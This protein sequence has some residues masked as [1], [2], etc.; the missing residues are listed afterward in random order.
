[1]DLKRQPGSNAVPKLA[2]GR[3][4]ERQPSTAISANKVAGRGV[5]TCPSLFL[6][7]GGAEKE[8]HNP[9]RAAARMPGVSSPYLEV[10]PGCTGCRVHPGCTKSLATRIDQDVEYSRGAEWPED[11]SIEHKHL[12]FWELVLDQDVEC[13]RGAEWPE[14]QSIEHNHLDFW[15][16]V[17]L[18]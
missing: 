8:A 3:T 6:G 4:I 1:V 13:S 15:E 14:G 17:F 10:Q 11:Q 9:D 2:I 5:W 7:G 16:L 18:S 12:D